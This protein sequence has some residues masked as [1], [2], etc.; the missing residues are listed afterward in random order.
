MTRPACPSDPALGRSVTYDFTQGP[1]SDWKAIGGTPTY[2]GN[3][4]GFSVA[5][6]GDSPLIQSNWYIMFG[7]VELTIKAAP[8][9]GIV[10]SA[11]LQS[12]DLDEIDW[13]WLGGNDAQVQ[14]NY[15][16]KGD[17]SSYSRGAFHDNAGSHDAFHT[18]TIEWTS[19]QL[20]WQIDGKT[21]RVVTPESAPA[22]EYP[23]SPMMVR[24]GIWAGG[25]PNNSPGTIRE[26]DTLMFAS[27]PLAN[28]SVEWAGGQTDYSKGPYTMYLK[29]ASVTDY[30]TGKSYSYSDKSGSWQS[31]TSEGGRING[32][33][34]AEAAPVES[35]P[36]VTATIQEPVPWSGTHRETS[37]FVTPSVWPW[38]PTTLSSAVVRST[39]VPPGW[40]SSGSGQVQPPSAA[41]V[42]E[43]TPAFSLFALYLLLKP[44]PSQ[45]TVHSTSVSSVS[46][47]ASS[48]PSG[49]E[50]TTPSPTSPDA[51]T[52]PATR[53]TV[54]SATA[55]VTTLAT[56]ASGNTVPA[57][58]VS[59]PASAAHVTASTDAA[60]S[61]SKVPVTM[62]ALC[63]LLG[64][65]FAIF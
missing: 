16:G 26:C 13:E 9:T 17:T 46:S 4:V 5:K 57:Q 27:Y 33:S 21:V 36:P 28:V 15:F 64:G 40:V 51:V 56:L 32:N 43:H 20:V 52:S 62:G 60:N 49:L 50:T 6:Q 7:R 2:D 1:S 3:G 45:S 30:S 8:G 14:T 61:L 55:G 24:I 22:N 11:V 29:S 63:A 54:S 23:Q 53:S 34:G 10:S 47:S 31:I 39:S 65:A 35:A 58:L 18:Y 12:D 19:S 42:S 38:V 37:S 44:L 25:D 41:S 48:S 59:S